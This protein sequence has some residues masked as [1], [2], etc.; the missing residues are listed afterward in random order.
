[1]HLVGALRPLIDA[2]RIKVYSCDSVAG[3]A[4]LTREGT[5]QHRM[6]LQNQFHQYIRHEVVPAIRTD[7]QTPRSSMWAAGASIGAFHSV[8]VVCRFPDVFV[9]ALRDVGH[10]RPA[11]V[12]RDRRVHRRLLGVVAAALRADA[13]RPPPRRAADPHRSCS[14]PARAAPRTSAS[15]G[16]WPTHSAPRASPTGSTPGGRAGTTTGRPGARCCRS[17]W[18]NGSAAAE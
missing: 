12:L 15:R 10:L 8:A 7:C 9:R 16:G 11:P 6:W 17:T 5:P 13:R 2:G 3:R 14:P 18:A 1:M 4:L